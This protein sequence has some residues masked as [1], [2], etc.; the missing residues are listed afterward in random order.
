MKIDV[1]FFAP[2][3][4]SS[5]FQFKS[6]QANL[7]GCDCTDSQRHNKCSVQLPDFRLVMTRHDES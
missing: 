7:K 4:S 6:E 5:V 1:V 2:A 3:A